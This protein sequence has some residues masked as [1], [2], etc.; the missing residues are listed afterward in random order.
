MNAGRVVCQNEQ[1]ISLS[2]NRK[3]LAQEKIKMKTVGLRIN[4]LVYLV[5][6]MALAGFETANAQTVSTFVSGLSEPNDVAFDSTGN[7]YVA[8][9]RSNK[10][11]KVTPAGGV[12]T[13]AGS[14]TYGS[15]EVALTTFPTW[16]VSLNRSVFWCS[17]YVSASRDIFGSGLDPSVRLASP[18]PSGR[19]KS[20]LL[21]RFTFLPVGYV[22]FWPGRFGFP[23]HPK[24]C[25]S[26]WS[27]D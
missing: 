27:A 10:I 6:L 17:P 16:S 3:T 13:F 19:M 15:Q 26:G 2:G 20:D 9:M 12:S 1:A 5:M 24:R 22:S 23:L 21:S 7:M 18:T 14:G 11:L 8:A 4:C 25:H